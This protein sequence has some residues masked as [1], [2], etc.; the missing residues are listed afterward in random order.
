MIDAV[1]KPAR[2]RALG[3][4]EID[5]LAARVA[6]LSERA[7]DRENAIKE[8][9]FAVFHS[10]RHLIF[11]FIERNQDR[12]VFYSN[13]SWAVWKPLLQ[14]VIDQAIAPYGFA[15]PVVPK[16]M[17]ARLEANARIDRHIDEAPSNPTVHKIHVP[18]VTNPS[19]LFEIDGEVFHFERGHAVEVNNIVPHAA[20]NGGDT[21]R[22]HLIFE[23]FDAASGAQG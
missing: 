23:V 22:I 6:Q 12:R 11:R 13:P 3:P 2:V 1:D 21:D 5:P 14:P 7:W 10:T 17:L 20:T 16:A 4:V 8:N 18:I 9:D 19:A 15:E